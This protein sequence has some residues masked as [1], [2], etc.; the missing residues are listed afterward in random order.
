MYSV[1]Q[2]TDFILTKHQNK[3]E[4]HS[5]LKEFV[6]MITNSTSSMDLLNDEISELVLSADN[7]VSRIKNLQTDVSDTYSIGAQTVVAK[8][9]RYSEG[10]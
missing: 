5:M 9:A 10:T 2:I 7:S 8:G 1:S 3:K 4:F 6:D